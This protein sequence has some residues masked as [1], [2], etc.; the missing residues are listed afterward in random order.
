M[1]WSSYQMLG[2]KKA[3]LEPYIWARKALYNDCPTPGD[4]EPNHLIY[5]QTP[6]IILHDQEECLKAQTLT[7]T[8]HTDKQKAARSLNGD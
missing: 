5:R 4:M 3:W 8:L 6:S 1:S 7:E 2:S